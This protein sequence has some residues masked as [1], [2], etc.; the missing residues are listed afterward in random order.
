MKYRQVSVNGMDVCFV[1][2][3]SHQEISKRIG[4]LSTYLVTEWK[5]LLLAKIEFFRV[6]VN[7]LRLRKPTS[8][9]KAK[10]KAMHKF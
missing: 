3:K 2:V 5:R 9:T 4:G 10:A 7:D 6:I 8:L 1:Y